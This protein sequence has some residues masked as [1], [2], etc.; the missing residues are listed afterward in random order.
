M[1]REMSPREGIDALERD[2]ENRA[3][4]IVPK[5]DA[6]DA[7]L[8]AANRCIEDARQCLGDPVLDGPSDEHDCVSA[9]LQTIGTKLLDVQKAITNLRSFLRKDNGGQ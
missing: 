3:K 9:D 6:A 8:S 4:R 1:K 2:R 5:W 7:V